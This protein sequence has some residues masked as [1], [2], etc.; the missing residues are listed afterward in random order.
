MKIAEFL[1]QIALTV[2][3]AL[4]DALAERI[5]SKHLM[6]ARRAAWQREFAYRADLLRTV[7]GEPH[8]RARTHIPVMMP[9]APPL[10]GNEFSTSED[11]PVLPEPPPESGA[12]ARLVEQEFS[13]Y[14]QGRA[15]FIAQ[16]NRLYPGRL[17]L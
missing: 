5:A 14:V 13:T 16:L 3:P 11:D 7:R 17:P 6:R 15:D 8:Y 2:A 10:P 12:F 9:P 1:D 4:P